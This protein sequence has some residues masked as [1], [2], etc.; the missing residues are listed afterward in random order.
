MA[1]NA[2]KIISLQ[3]SQDELANALKQED[4]KRILSDFHMVNKESAK[5]IRHAISTFILDPNAMTLRFLKSQGEP[6][7]VKKVG[8]V[9]YSYGSSSADK[10]NC[11]N[12]PSCADTKAFKFIFNLIDFTVTGVEIT[13]ASGK[14]IQYGDS[15]GFSQQLL[16]RINALG[17]E[18]AVLRKKLKLM[19]DT[20]CQ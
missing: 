4:R 16:D 9:G 12:D 19:A 3:N 18:N 1:L 6:L 14:M 15:M 17:Q 5:K 10:F 8:N 7:C 13:D 20:L 11:A 2:N